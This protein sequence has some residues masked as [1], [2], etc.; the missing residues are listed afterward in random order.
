LG[1]ATYYGY[2]AVFASSTS[3]I[4]PDASTLIIRSLVAFGSHGLWGAIEGAAFYLSHNQENKKFITKRFLAWMGLSVAFH[5]MWNSN[6]FFVSSV[7][8][9]IIIMIILQVMMIGVFLFIMDACIRDNKLTIQNM[10]NEENVVTKITE[11]D[12]GENVS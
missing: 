10:I 4:M 8:V 3:F 5:I 6:A 12:K 1:Y 2:E 9:R 7:S 11:S